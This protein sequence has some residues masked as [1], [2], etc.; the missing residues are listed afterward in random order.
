MNKMTNDRMEKARGNTPIKTLLTMRPAIEFALAGSTGSLH[1]CTCELCR[2][3]ALAPVGGLGLSS[4]NGWAT[5]LVKCKVEDEDDSIDP[6]YVED[7]SYTVARYSGNGWILA[8]DW[9]YD[10]KVL[11]WL[12]IPQLTPKKNE[13]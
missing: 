12:Q 3:R 13:L 11:A 1:P 8:D 10:C 4:A 6:D 2:H 9:Y 7:L 5:V